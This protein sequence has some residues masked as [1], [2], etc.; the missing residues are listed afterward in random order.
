MLKHIEKIMENIQAIFENNEEYKD[1]KYIHDL[2]CLL[3]QNSDNV[4]IDNICRR[5]L[6]DLYRAYDLYLIFVASAGDSMSDSLFEKLN[7]KKISKIYTF[8]CTNFSSTL[9]VCKNAYLVN[10]L[11]M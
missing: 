10:M 6:D 11:N 5:Y 4:T 3:E 2:K 9:H 8:N 7:A 1:L